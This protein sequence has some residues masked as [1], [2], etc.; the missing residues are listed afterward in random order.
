MHGRS[1][2]QTVEGELKA[3][4]LKL[5][6]RVENGGPVTVSSKIFATWFCFTDG[7]CESRASIDGVLINPSGQ[8]VFSFGDFL[9]ENLEEIFYKESKHPIYEVELLP[10]LVA[11]MLWGDTMSQCQAVFFLDNDAAKV[12]L[13]KGSGATRLASLVISQFCEREAALQRKTWFSRVPSYS[14]LK[15]NGFPA[16]R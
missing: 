4:L 7:A 1:T 13:I 16:H 6:E 3:T 12:G 8:A 5:L 14:N 9:P 2:N 10:V 11:A 15:Q